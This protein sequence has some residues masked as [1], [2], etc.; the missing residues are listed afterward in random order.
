MCQASRRWRWHAVGM[1]CVRHQFHAFD[2]ARTRAAEVRGAIGG[3]EIEVLEP[4]DKSTRAL[5]LDEGGLFPELVAPEP[6]TKEDDSFP[7]LSSRTASS[8]G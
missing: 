3:E 5:S 8:Q 4:I 2:H 7:L 6:E 1:Q